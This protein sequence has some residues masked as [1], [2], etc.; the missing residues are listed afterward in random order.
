MEHPGINV[1][2]IKEEMS[3][4]EM[5]AQLKD[6]IMKLNFAYTTGNQPLIQQLTMV[7]ES[8]TRA[9]LEKLDEMFGDDK[10]NA[11]GQIDIS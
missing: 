10:E 4:E 3:I 1:K 5:Q 9:Q 6:I 2:K 8:Y 7:K 11:K